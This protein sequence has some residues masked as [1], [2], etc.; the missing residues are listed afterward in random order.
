[1]SSACGLLWQAGKHGRLGKM[2]EATGTSASWRVLANE[3][4]LLQQ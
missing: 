1:M 4:Q 2:S 3:A